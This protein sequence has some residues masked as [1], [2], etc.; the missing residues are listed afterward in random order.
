MEV[1]LLVWESRHRHNRFQ[2]SLNLVLLLGKCHC[3][4]NDQSLHIN[5]PGT[6]IPHPRSTTLLVPHQVLPTPSSQRKSHK[7]LLVTNSVPPSPVPKYQNYSASPQHRQIQ[8]PN[9]FPIHLITQLPPL[10]NPPNKNQ[11]FQNS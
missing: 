1:K 10:N 2:W 5:L 3:P 6:T 9:T 7:A 4:H 8:N 11:S